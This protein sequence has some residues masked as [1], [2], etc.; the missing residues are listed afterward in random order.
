MSKSLTAIMLTALLLVIPNLVS[1]RETK[2][3]EKTKQ[4]E[5]QT[6]EFVV[7]ATRIE[8]PSREVGSSVTV[9]TAKEIEEKQK[10]T[11]LEILRT[12]PALDVVQSGGPGGTTSIFIRGAKSEYTLVL[13]DGIEMNDPSSAGR[14]YNFSNLTPDNIKRIEIIRGPQSTLYGSDAI[15]GVINIITKKGKGKARGFVSLEGGSFST[16]RETAGL[17]GGSKLLNFSLGLSRWDTDGISAANKKDGNSEKDGYENTSISARLG[18]TPT[19]NSDIDFILRY[20]KDKSDIDNFGGVG[21][22]DPNNTAVGEQL[23]FRTQLRLALLG[24]L[25]EQKLGFSLT[26]YNR[27]YRNNTDTKHPTDFS[28]GSYDGEELRFDW[29]HNLYLHETNTLTIGLENEEERAKSDYYSESAWGSYTSVFGKKTA[30]TISYYLQDQ[31]KLWDSCFTTLGVRLDDHSR[32]GTKVTYRIA[33][34]YLIKQT[35]TKLKGTYGTGFKAPSLYYLYSEYGDEDL[36]PEESTGWDIGVEQALF[37]FAKK[38]TIAATYFSNK[39]DNMIEY[40][41]STWMFTNVAAAKTEGVEVSASVRPTDDLTLQANYT[42]TKTKDKTTGEELLRRPKNKLGITI[43]YH[44]FDKGNV[45]LDIVYTGSRDDN[46]YS[47]WPAARVKLDSYTLV[48]LAAS[49]QVTKS[50]QVFGRAENLLNKEYEE[51]KGYGTPGI[52]AFAGA[53]LS[54]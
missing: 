14:S 6:E 9:I 27:D 32:F 43:N 37:G 30:R 5:F 7:T 52:S 24:D 29:Q 11:V 17:S 15:G 42:Y 47:T 53:R 12:V 33:S 16:L 46:D 19:E 4:N 50:T 39:F 13:I 21:G 51:V 2:D 44:F 31:I 45:N 1:A 20:I 23:F 48:N 49:Y 3:A 35:G 54:F 34:A 10:T 41:S 26:D 36:A 40:D 38:L 28:R 8:T 22:D 25:W 18:V